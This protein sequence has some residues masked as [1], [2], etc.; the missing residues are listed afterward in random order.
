M[1][2]NPETDAVDE[3]YDHQETDPSKCGAISSSLWEI[4]SLQEHVL[5]QVKMSVSVMVKHED[6]SVSV[7]VK[8]AHL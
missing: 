8:P 7:M 3:T 6:V 5:P 4:V 1:I 2:D